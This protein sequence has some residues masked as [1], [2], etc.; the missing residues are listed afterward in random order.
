MALAVASA[1]TQTPTVLGYW[2]EPGG[3]IIRVAPCPQQLCVEIAKLPAGKHGTTDSHNPDPKLRN[4]PLCGLWVGAGFIAIDP[5]HAREGHLYDPRSG[6]TYSGE[7]TAEGNLLH[8][9][10]YVGL[11]IFGRTETWVRAAPPPPC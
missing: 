10:G 1:Y 11:R 8:L 4:R 9:R 6:R 3:S 7:M 2:R 5:Q